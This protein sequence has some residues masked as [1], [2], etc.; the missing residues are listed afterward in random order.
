MQ[1]SNVRVLHL[2]SILKYIFINSHQQ[3]LHLIENIIPENSIFSN[4]KSP[5]QAS[6]NK[7]IISNDLLAIPFQYETNCQDYLVATSATSNINK[8]IAIAS[9]HNADKPL[10]TRHGKIEGTPMKDQFFIDF[11]DKEYAFKYD[12]E[13][14]KP[15]LPEI[16]SMK[17]LIITKF[18][19][20]K[21][22]S[23]K[24]LI[25]MVT[26]LGTLDLLINFVC[27]ARKASI[28]ISNLVVFVGQPE[29]RDL[30]ISLGVF[31]VYSDAYVN[32]PSKPS[33]S[34]GD[35]TFAKMMWLKVINT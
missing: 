33:G 1:K 11:A 15:F 35:R 6:E 31:S 18:G 25:V 4:I 13:Y 29:L 9:A 17:R 5:V 19:H 14:L 21:N 3:N 7:F 27:S 10:M 23:N 22:N 26:N 16:E 2:L 32:L 8:C 28:D 24:N 20:P 12:H 34:Y 30:L